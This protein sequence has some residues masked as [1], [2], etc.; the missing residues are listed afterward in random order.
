MG[1]PITPLAAMSKIKINWFLLGFMVLLLTQAGLLYFNRHQVKF[2]DPN[3]QLLKNLPTHRSYFAAREFYDEAYNSADS[4]INELSEKVYGG[5]IP[6][7]LLVKDKIAA[8]FKGIES[9]NYQTV[10]L[11]G[12]N[13]FNQGRSKIILSQAN[14]QTP[15]GILEPD[16]ELLNNLLKDKNTAIEEDSFINE[17][18]ISGLVAFI[19]KSLPHAKIVPIILKIGLTQSELEVFSAKL[20]SDIDSEKTLVLASVDFSHYQPAAVADFHDLRTNNLLQSFDLSRLPSAEVDSP[21]SLIVLEKYLQSIMAQKSQLIFSTNSGAIL[22]LPD[23]PSTSHNF[24]YFFKGEPEKNQVLDLLFFGD[25]MLDRHIKE[26]ITSKGFDYLLAK[27][28]GGEKRFFTGLDLISANLEGAVT[29]LGEHY[30]PVAGND[31]AFAPQTVKKLQNYN[32]IFFNL[33]NNHLSDQGTKGITET[34]NNLTDLN[35]SFAGCVDGKTGECSYKIMDLGGKKIGLA[36]FSMVYQPFDLVAAGQIIKDLKAKTDLT[37]VNVHWGTEYEHQFSAKQQIVAHSLIEAGADVIIGHHPH[38]I[39]G[40]E[41]YQGKPIFYSLGNFIFDQYFS[42]DTQQGLAI[43]LSVD[44]FPAKSAKLSVYLF[45]FES[46]VAQ[47][48]LMK[49]DQKNKLLSNFSDWS[50]VDELVKKQI[51]QGL[52][53][54]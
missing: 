18:A 43:G 40:L 4:Q 25:I 14:W 42:A 17:Q 32:F 39:Q 22:K 19:K 45:P 13:H 30:P 46:A 15:Y 53:K 51:F 29:D 9:S 5:I 31:F 3:I 47:A 12:P 38:V 8:W 1:R 33:A 48:S 26:K 54:L 23:E 20:N 52:L 34:G 24:Y 35:F 27:L 21:V 10:V 50:K 44:F 28:A 11:I 41:I 6:H 37:V 16:L 36:G 2:I 49:I 7:H